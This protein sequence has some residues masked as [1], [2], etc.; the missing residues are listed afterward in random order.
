M[1]R[2][3]F[4]LLPAPQTA[5]M[6]YHVLKEKQAMN[7]F[8]HFSRFSSNLSLLMRQSANSQLN[9]LIRQIKHILQ[10]CFKIACGLIDSHASCPFPQLSHEQHVASD[11]TGVGG[12]REGVAP[13][14]GAPDPWIGFPSC[15]KLYWCIGVDTV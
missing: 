3:H 15:L 14:V 13:G 8:S 1:I 12:C 4:P 9:Q 7:V 6:L 5:A 2:V 11:R 10:K